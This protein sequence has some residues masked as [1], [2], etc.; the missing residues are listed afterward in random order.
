MYEIGRV[1][2]WQN[3]VGEWAYVNG[4]ETTVLG[5]VEEYRGKDSGMLYKGQRVDSPML[6]PWHTY[7]QPG[8]LRPKNPPPGERKINELFRAPELET[9]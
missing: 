6:L 1:Y 7:A 8:D 5:P 2:I 4:S 9:T 3:Q